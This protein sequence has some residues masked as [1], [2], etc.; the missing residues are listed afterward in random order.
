M[1]DNQHSDAPVRRVM[2]VEDDNSFGELLRYQLKREGFEPV[3]V[4]SGEE[5]LARLAEID[6][7]VI[8]MDIMLPGIDGCAL[9]GEIHPLHK[10]LPI[11]MMTAAGSVELAVD[12]MKRGAYDFLTKPFDFD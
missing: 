8:L 9:L 7:D 10:E 2:V 6:P 4:R 1:S 12:C 11:V 3:I 5:G